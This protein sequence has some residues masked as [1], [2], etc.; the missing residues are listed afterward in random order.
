MYGTLLL[1]KCRY[2]EKQPTVCGMAFI[3]LRNAGRSRWLSVSCSVRAGCASEIT[4][5]AGM[6][7]SP[8]TSTPVTWVSSHTMRVTFCRV[9]TEPP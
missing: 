7:V 5:S 9:T 4:W 1:L 3:R 8:F 6:K 2:T